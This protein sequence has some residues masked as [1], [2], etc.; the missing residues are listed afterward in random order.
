MTL[1]KTDYKNALLKNGV[2]AFV[3]KGN[4]MWPFIKNGKNTVVVKTLTLPINALDVI[5]FERDNGDYVLHRVIKVE[6]NSYITVGDNFPHPERIQKSQV[7]GVMDGFYTN[8]KYTQATDEKYKK[9]VKKW[10]KNGLFVKARKG[11]FALKI[12][13]KTVIQRIFKRKKHNV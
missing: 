3:P 9:K 5:L 4:S 12:K 10:Y 13:T 2:V 7:L 11:F 1:T 8:E 6:E